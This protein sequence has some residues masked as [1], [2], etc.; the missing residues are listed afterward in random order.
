M[1]QAIDRAK[2][3]EVA[4]HLE[5]VLNQYPESEEVRSLLQALGPL[6]EDA[7]AGRVLVPV[8]RMDIA[9]AWSFSDGRY[10][11]YKTP[12]IDSAYSDFVTELRGGLSDEEK[13]QIAW[14]EAKRKEF[15]APQ[16]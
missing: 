8:D 14:L 2:L 13:K 15:E 16:S 1:T 5:W 4:E 12:S 7:K 11:P 3:K 9:G 10:V 6:I